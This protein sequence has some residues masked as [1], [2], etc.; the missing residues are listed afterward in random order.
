MFLGAAFGEGRANAHLGVFVLVEHLRH[1][2]PVEVGHGGAGGGWLCK[3]A[4]TRV[5][6]SRYRLTAD[7][8]WLGPAPQP[9]Q[10]RV[11]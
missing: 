11:S 7:N 1:R 6:A 9:G 5:G 3:C 8:L 4:P 10:E 2:A